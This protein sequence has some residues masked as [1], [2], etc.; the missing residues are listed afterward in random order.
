[1]KSNKN[2]Q[3]RAKYDLRF[4][5]LVQDLVI[6]RKFLRVNQNKMS[7]LCGVSLR[8]I[9]NFENYRC[10]DYFLIFA[11]REILNNKI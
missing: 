6:K 2:Q 5:G 7:V 8:T 3:L 1:M 9:Q 4:F 11:Y 10:K